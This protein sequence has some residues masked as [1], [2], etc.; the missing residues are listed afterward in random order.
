[1]PGMHQAGFPAV[2]YVYQALQHFW[3]VG[4]ALVRPSGQRPETQSSHFE[5]PVSCK[6][7]TRNSEGGWQ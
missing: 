7:S 1:M 2:W 3:G 5:P 4:C 6:H